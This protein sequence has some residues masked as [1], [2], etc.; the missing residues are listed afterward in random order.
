MSL[1][2]KIKGIY[3]ELTEKYQR[4]K[5]RVDPKKTTRYAFI[6]EA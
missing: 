3:N 1:G 2:P 4:K 6:A 5:R